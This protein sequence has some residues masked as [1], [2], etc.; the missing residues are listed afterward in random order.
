MFFHTVM[1]HYALLLIQFYFRLKVGLNTNICPGCLA[2]THCY[3]WGC[4]IL[5]K[6]V[7]GFGSELDFL[8]IL[9]AKKAC[10]SALVAAVHDNL[11]RCGISVWDLPESDG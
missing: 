5:C 8:S 11:L 7:I 4:G 1:D 10:D 2:P 3:V 6:L 9:V